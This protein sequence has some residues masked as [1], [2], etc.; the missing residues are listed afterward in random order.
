LQ[1]FKFKMNFFKTFLFKR[2]KLIYFI[3]NIKTISKYKIF[4]ILIYI[5][6]LMYE[7]KLKFLK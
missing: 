6:I 2:I 3:P 7:F 4:I 1:Y 5:K